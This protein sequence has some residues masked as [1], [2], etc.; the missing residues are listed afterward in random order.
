MGSKEPKPHTRWLFMKCLLACS[1]DDTGQ[2][3]P[4]NWRKC[5]VNMTMMVSR[6]WDNSTA[7]N[8]LTFAIKFTFQSLLAVSILS[9]V[10]N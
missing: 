4:S 10:Y 3:A 7:N 2:D 8:A 5:S 9:I 1:F 6:T